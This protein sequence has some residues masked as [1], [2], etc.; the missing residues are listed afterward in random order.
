MQKPNAFIFATA[1]AK[2]ALQAKGATGRVRDA[3]MRYDRIFP[4]GACIAR[5]AWDGTFQIATLDD[6]PYFANIP[7]H[8]EGIVF[9]FAKR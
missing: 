4:K 3:E 8:L 2:W 6:T 1:M 9:K 5:R 7:A